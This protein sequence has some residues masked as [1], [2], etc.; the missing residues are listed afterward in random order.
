M[1]VTGIR[2]RVVRLGDSEGIYLDKLLRNS[3]DLKKNDIVELSIK[4][5]MGKKKWS[6]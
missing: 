4:K 2:K 5:I 6:K 1:I 3:L